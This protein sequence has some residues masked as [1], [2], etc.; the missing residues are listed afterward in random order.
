MLASRIRSRSILTAFPD[1]DILYAYPISCSILGTEEM[2]PCSVARLVS[3]S[4][5]PATIPAVTRRRDRIVVQSEGARAWCIRRSNT[6]AR[7]IRTPRGDRP[8]ADAQAEAWRD[9]RSR[10]NRG[11]CGLERRHRRARRDRAHQ[12]HRPGSPPGARRFAS[13]RPRINVRF[14]DT[15]IQRLHHP[16]A[17]EHELTYGAMQFSADAGLTMFACTAGPGRK[18]EQALQLLG[19]RANSVRV[20]PRHHRPTLSASRRS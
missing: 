17:G 18:S 10:S 2:E 11:A 16:I 7:L 6:S 8:D 3:R 1:P 15:G 9:S 20:R 19:S 5:W 4:I 14:H 12:V 13:N